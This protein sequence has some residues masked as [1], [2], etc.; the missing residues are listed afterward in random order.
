MASWGGVGYVHDH[1]NGVIGATRF[2]VTARDNFATGVLKEVGGFIVV[3]YF[4]KN[5]LIGGDL[6]RR[7]PNVGR[8]VGGN[9]YGKLFGSWVGSNWAAR[10]GK[11]MI[12]KFG[13]VALY[14]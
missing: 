10:G 8:G 12:F 9:I 2:G 13:R 1:A 11:E 3:F 14:M 6:Q 7:S 4:A 5:P